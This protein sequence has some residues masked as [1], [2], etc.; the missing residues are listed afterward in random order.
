MNGQN[1]RVIFQVS[2]FMHFRGMRTFL[3]KMFRVILSD[4]RFLGYM[5]DNLKELS[6]KRELNSGM[7]AYCKLELHATEPLILQ[8]LKNSEL[9]TWKYLHSAA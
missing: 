4:T 7:I 9:I 5:A 6:C 2:Y 8:D 3:A 1:A